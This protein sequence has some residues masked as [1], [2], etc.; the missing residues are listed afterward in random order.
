MSSEGSLFLPVSS[1]LLGSA[2][3]CDPLLNFL[4][5]YGGKLTCLAHASG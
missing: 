1:Y 4:L 3:R 5:F 2:V